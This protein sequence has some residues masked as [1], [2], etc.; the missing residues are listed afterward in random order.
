MQIWCGAG[1]KACKDLSGYLLCLTGTPQQAKFHVLVDV[2]HRLS[3]PV[4]Q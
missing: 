4:V 3:L 2:F 1:K